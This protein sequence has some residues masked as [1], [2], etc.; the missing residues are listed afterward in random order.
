MIVSDALVALSTFS[1]AILFLTGGAE[2]L[3]V[4]VTLLIR[5]IAGNF[6]FPAMRASTSLMVPESNLSK[7][8]GYNQILHNLL[9]IVTP[10]LGAFLMSALPLQSILMID[11]L[12]ALLGITPLFFVVIPQPSRVAGPYAAFS[13]WND[14]KAG[15]QYIL[16]MPGFVYI[17]AIISV[18][19]FFLDPAF[20]LTPI[21][22]QNHFGGGVMQ[23]AW[24]Q[25][26][27]SIGGLTSGLIFSL[28][29][30][31]KKV[32]TSM[33][34][35]AGVG[36]GC[37]MMGLAPPNALWLAITGAFL[38]TIMMGISDAPMGALLQARIAP[39]MQG[40]VFAVMGSLMTIL[41][42]LALLIAGPLA[43]RFGVQIWFMAGGAMCL[44]LGLLASRMPL[45]L[46]LEDQ[47]SI[48]VSGSAQPPVYPSPDRE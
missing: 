15:G 22:V 45:I 18:L 1:L 46:Q 23:F 44:L 31:R 10:P 37:L 28:W 20:S 7:I 47:P 5:A 4:Y 13:P 6:Q 25:S 19:N 41:S 2:V 21:L 8:A 33:L 34:G 3:H 38:T 17:I 32:L 48:N 29:V 40:R 43:D 42:P 11:V 12:T 9:R 24:V 35:V 39:E 26:A 14:L 36:L 30:V 16:S 27:A